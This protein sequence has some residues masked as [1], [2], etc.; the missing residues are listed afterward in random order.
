MKRLITLTSTVAL[1]AASPSLVE[2]QQPP[3]RASSC[4]AIITSYEAT[5]LPPG[6]VGKEVSG[7]ASTPG[8]GRRLVGPLARTH[9]GSIEACL[10]A[11][12]PR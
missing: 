11:E 6:A 2:A 4:V 5:Q 7:L 1:L 9:L 10:A 8:L 12:T 3:S